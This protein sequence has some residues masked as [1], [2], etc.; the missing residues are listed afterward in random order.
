LT[1]RTEQ[2]IAG[3]LSSGGVANALLGKSP[4]GSAKAVFSVVTAD[5]ALLQAH[6]QKGVDGLAPTG[7][8]H[9]L[10]A[11]GGPMHTG[12]AFNWTPDRIL[13]V[14]DPL[15]NAL[16]ALSLGD[17]GT[18]FKAESTRTITAP[19]LATPIDLAAAV[20]E[21]A[22]P[23]FSSNT[24]LAGGSDLYVANRGNG[25]LVRIRQDGHVSTTTPRAWPATTPRAPAVAAPTAWPR[26]CG[27]AS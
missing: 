20:P 12:A 6:A 14:A 19:E 16:V 1:N 11:A 8:I 10:T 18:V 26:C 27:S 2:R 21:V 7:T 13:Y 5:G 9:P 22:N 17:D 24:T 4:D 15:G 25:S 3:S 23:D